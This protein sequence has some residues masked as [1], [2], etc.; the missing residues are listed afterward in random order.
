MPPAMDPGVP[1][2]STKPQPLGNYTIVFLFTT[3][4]LCAMYLL[5]RKAS[6]FRTVVAHQLSTWQG[7]G[8]IRLSTD[9][10]PPARSF[11]DEDHDDDSSSHDDEPLPA[12]PWMPAGSHE[13]P[14]LGGTGGVPP[15]NPP[16]VPP[17]P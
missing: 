16:P 13:P 15:Q 3:C 5:W 6:S 17:K 14:P 1:R 2:E 7:E 4:T 11:I 12:A 8:R 9:E 10:G